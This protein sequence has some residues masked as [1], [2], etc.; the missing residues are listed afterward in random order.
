MATMKSSSNDLQSQFF[1]PDVHQVIVL[2]FR[3]YELQSTMSIRFKLYSDTWKRLTCSYNFWSILAPFFLLLCPHFTM[4]LIPPKLRVC[5]CG[6]ISKV[7]V[8]DSLSHWLSDNLIYQIWTT[9]TWFLGWVNHIVKE[10]TVLQDH[11]LGLNI[12]SQ[13]ANHWCVVPSSL[14][15]KTKSFI[16]C[17]HP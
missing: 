16:W 1:I 12:R 10:N 17:P 9:T 14:S 11:L 8:V 2:A 3:R 13:A 5:G 7:P 4:L 6:I 15:S